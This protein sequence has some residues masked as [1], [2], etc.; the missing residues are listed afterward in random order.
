MNAPHHPQHRHGGPAN[1]HPHPLCHARRTPSTIKCLHPAVHQGRPL[2]RRTWA[3]S[4]EFGLLASIPEE[5]VYTGRR[6]AGNHRAQ[7]S[8]GS[9]RGVPTL[10]LVVTG[11]GRA[12]RAQRHARADQEIRVTRHAPAKRRCAS[13]SPSPTPVIQQLAMTTLAQ[14][15]GKGGWTLNGQS[16]HLRARDADYMFVGAPPALPKSRTA[17]KACR[18][19]CST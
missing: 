3:V 17:P 11:L 9:R 14:P 18:C 4:G 5:Y 12:H 1:A 13:P 15:N 6:R 10:F 8:P 2:P 19:S 7:R 16:V